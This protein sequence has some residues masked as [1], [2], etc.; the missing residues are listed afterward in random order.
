MRR[1]FSEALMSLA[2]LSL[3]LLV[4]VVADGRLREQISLRVGDPSSQLAG[5]GAEVRDLT[6]VV[7]EVLRDQTIDHAVMLIFVLAA[8]VLVLFMLRT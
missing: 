5:A 3:L 7:F 6:T 1:A 2:T 8:T 4:L